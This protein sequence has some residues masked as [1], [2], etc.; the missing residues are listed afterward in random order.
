M[1]YNSVIFVCNDVI[2]SIDL[3]LISWWNKTSKALYFV[4]TDGLLGDW[5][6]VALSNG[7]GLGKPT[8][9]A[10]YGVGNNAN[11]CQAVYCGHADNTVLIAAGGNYASV[12]GTFSGYKHHT[13]ES[14]VKLLKEWANQ[15]G[16]RVVKKSA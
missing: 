2:G 9:L 11:G 15:L 10:D 12:L 4:G 14:Q 3:D 7:I 6:Q 8:D 16:Y 1:G 13:Q 5:A